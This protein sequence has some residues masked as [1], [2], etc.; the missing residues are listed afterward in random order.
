MAYE[1]ADALIKAK[2][3]E[4]AELTDEALIELD[5]HFTEFIERLGTDNV[6]S[7]AVAEEVYLRNR[8]ACWVWRKWF[9]RGGRERSKRW[10]QHLERRERRS[11]T[12]AEEIVSRTARYR[13]AE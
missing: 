3:A 1:S 11:T 10:L 6:L 2:Q 8:H 12:I 7:V 4:V 9:S 5:D 13:D